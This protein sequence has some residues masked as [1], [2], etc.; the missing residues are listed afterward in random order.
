MGELIGAGVNLPYETRVTILASRCIAVWDVLKACLRDGS[1]DSEIDDST[2]VPN[3]F[4][5]FYTTHLGIT[6]VFFNGAK[7]ESAYK[8]HIWRI[9]SSRSQGLEYKRLPSTSPANTSIKFPEKVTE[10]K[11]ILR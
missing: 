11:A 1:L 8:K 5:S 7:A 2:I 4:K 10:W 3:D 9:L 6:H